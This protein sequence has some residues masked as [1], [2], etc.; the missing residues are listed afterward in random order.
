MP[1]SNTEFLLLPSASRTASLSTDVQ[2]NADRAGVILTL[3]ITSGAGSGGLLPQL[4]VVNVLTGAT[5][6]VTRAPMPVRSVGTY[7]YHF[8]P[9]ADGAGVRAHFYAPIFLPKSWLVTIT[10]EGGLPITYSLVGQYVRG[11]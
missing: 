7:A 8:Y 6:L 9:F 5:E 1:G 3:D 2:E 10:H 4:R 11:G